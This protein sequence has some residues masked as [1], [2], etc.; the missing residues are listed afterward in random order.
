MRLT[1]EIRE[2]IRAA[3]RGKP[4]VVGSKS[5]ADYVRKIGESL[6][7]EMFVRKTWGVKEWR[8]FIVW[9]RASRTKSKLQKNA[10]RIT[11]NAL[12][13]GKIVRGKC[14]CGE[15]GHA[16]HPDYRKPLDIQWLCAKHHAQY[17]GF[18]GRPK[19]RE[20]V[21]KQFKSVS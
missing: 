13:N 10:Y 17:H 6:G 14:F 2:A 18:L 11:G 1:D 3:K 12:N 9:R 7:V 15:E 5:R 20:K 16:H 4:I 8:C 19:I 21:R